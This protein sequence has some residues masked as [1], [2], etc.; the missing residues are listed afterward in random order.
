MLMI[1]QQQQGVALQH[2]MPD[3]AHRP[4]SPLLKLSL[5]FPKQKQ[6]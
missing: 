3:M 1:S 5:T 6:K 4:D 2:A